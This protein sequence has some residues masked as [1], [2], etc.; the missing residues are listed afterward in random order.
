MT[1]SRPKA[2][3]GGQSLF[4]RQKIACAEPREAVARISEVDPGPND[5]VTALIPSIMIRTL[6]RR[7]RL[8]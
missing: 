4:R 7:N 1:M 3:D 5:C 2:T 8:G 6:L